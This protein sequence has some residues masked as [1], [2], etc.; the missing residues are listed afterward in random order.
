MPGPLD[1]IL[2]D[3]R[4]PG[5][6][7]LRLGGNTHAG[8]LE[9]FQTL[10]ISRWVRGDHS[11][12]PA[13]DEILGRISAEALR[14]VFRDVRNA[15]DESSR[16]FLLRIERIGETLDV[17]DHLRSLTGFIAE[18]SPNFY[19]TTQTELEPSGP[20]V[21]HL[22]AIAWPG[23]LALGPGAP[24]EVAVLD[25][26]ISPHELL[27]VPG[28]RSRDMV[29]VG[30]TVPPQGY[31]W[32]GD[33]AT[34]DDQPLDEIGHGT[35]VAGLIGAGPG[36]NLC[37]VCPGAQ[38]RSI[39]VMATAVPIAGGPQIGFA[40]ARDVADAIEFASSSDSRIISMSFGFPRPTPVEVLAVRRA[41]QRGA[42]MVAAAGN[43]GVGAPPFFPANYQEVICV[44]A[45]TPTG[46]VASFSQRTP[47]MDCVSP[48]VDLRSTS[49]G[50]ETELR[51]GTSMATAVVSGCIAL[52]LKLRPGL[53]KD[54]VLELLRRTASPV[55]GGPED[56]GFGAINIGAAVRLMLQIT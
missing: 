54:R 28:N 43:N 47:Q 44:G 8:I 12:V 46:A 56:R 9:R 18:V 40:T 10:A 50:G 7:L 15:V 23:A 52:L 24:R 34:R 16:Y 38:L 49:L 14:P 33:S 48:G 35:H 13:L 39:R 30:T 53:G 21:P 1:A 4:V 32:V 2:E 55:T 6:L 11:G 19:R 51:S 29:D 3:P 42:I 20:A 45:L 25:T 27:R 17:A 37:G 22:Q 41:H 5:E 36:G 26:G 31:R